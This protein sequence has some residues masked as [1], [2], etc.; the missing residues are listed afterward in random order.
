MQG[1]EN[2]I[3]HTIPVPVF[4]IQLPWLGVPF[5]SFSYPNVNTYHN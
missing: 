4:S 3:M 5:P 1:Y 2:Y